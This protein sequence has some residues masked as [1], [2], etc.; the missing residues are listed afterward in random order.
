MILGKRLKS[1]AC[2]EKNNVY[3]RLSGWKKK[4][5]VEDEKSGDL[6]YYTYQTQIDFICLIC[7]LKETL[8]ESSSSWHCKVKEGVSL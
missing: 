3:S 1:E 7:F 2:I 6:G 4:G 5:F 8:T